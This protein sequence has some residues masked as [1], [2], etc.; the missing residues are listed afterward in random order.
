MPAKVLVLGGGVG[1]VVASTL[2]KRIL[3]HDVY[4]TLVDRNEHHR[5]AASFPLHD[6]RMALYSTFSLF[7]HWWLQADERR[8][9][10][11]SARPGDALHYEVD[12]E[13]AAVFLGHPVSAGGNED[14]TKGPAHLLLGKDLLAVEVQDL[15]GL[16]DSF[17]RPLLQNR[18]IML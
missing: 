2:L 7:A 6:N 17:R 3:G 9:V 14:G 18:M 15:A 1:G 4:V 13:I 5:Y 12:A 8:N 16:R 11:P 10:S